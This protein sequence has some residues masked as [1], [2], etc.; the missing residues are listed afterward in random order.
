ML[1][2]CGQDN[3]EPGVCHCGVGVMG[4]QAAGKLRPLQA[5]LLLEL[6]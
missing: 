3:V 6:L 1:G 5:E 4:P 2:L